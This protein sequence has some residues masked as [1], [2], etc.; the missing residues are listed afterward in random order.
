MKEYG[1]RII[2]RYANRKLYDTLESR[3]VTLEQVAEIV[4]EGEEVKV[5]DNTSKEDLTS[6]T[7]A[8][9]I[10]EEEKKQR[11]FLPLAALRNIIRTGGD[12][13][14]GFMSQ[15]TE[16]AERVGRVFR[17]EAEAQ[18]AGLAPNQ[19]SAAESSDEKIPR[20][21]RGNPDV[22]KTLRDFLDGVQSAIDEWQR[23]IDT[24]IHHALIN[25]SPLAPLQKELHHISQRIIGLE[26]KIK[27]LEKNR[28]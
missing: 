25:V 10:F 24:N 21:D 11:S 3:Y 26:Q 4:R 27:L 13:L 17:S 28:E 5:L 19:P 15:L 8:Q 12:S 9:I 14:S 23:K 2:K 1:N 7:L 16:S 18:A 22:T 20:D 6:V